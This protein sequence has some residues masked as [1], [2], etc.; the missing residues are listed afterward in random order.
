MQCEHFLGFT[1]NSKKP[2][3]LSVHNLITGE[4]ATAVAMFQQEVGTS[5]LVS[6]RSWTMTVLGKNLSACNLVIFFR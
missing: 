1:I 3:V 6:V 2:I 4:L 5:I